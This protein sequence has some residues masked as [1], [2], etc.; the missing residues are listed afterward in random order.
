MDI[1]KTKKKM[2]RRGAYPILS[3]TR[4]RLPFFSL[5]NQ[6]DRLL[7]IV[8][9]SCTELY[10]IVCHGFAVAHIRSYRSRARGAHS[11][12]S[13]IRKTD[14]FSLYIIVVQNCTSLCAMGSPWRIS[15][16]IAHA[17]EAPILFI[18][19]PLCTNPHFS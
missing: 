3:L 5:Y 1:K 17:P 8:Y 2:V 6:K 15:D 16:P 11:F 7:F 12:L 14:S 13:T 19:L 18:V 4:P 10:I 9:N